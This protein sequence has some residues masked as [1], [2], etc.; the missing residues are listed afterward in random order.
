MCNWY[1][2]KLFVVRRQFSGSETSENCDHHRLQAVSQSLF[3]S[4]INGEER[5]TNMHRSVTVSRCCEPLVV[6]VLKMASYRKHSDIHREGTGVVN[7]AKEKGGF[8]EC[9]PPPSYF[10]SSIRPTQNPPPPTTSPQFYAYYA[11]SL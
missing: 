4:K 1:T 6:Q 8:R 11:S 7:N 2:L 5:K 9:F 10:P 3:S